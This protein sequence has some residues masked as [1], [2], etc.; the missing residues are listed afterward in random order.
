[1]PNRIYLVTNIWGVFFCSC[2]RCICIQLFTGKQYLYGK[3]SP[4]KK[5]NRSFSSSAGC[6]GGA[7]GIIYAK[8]IQY[9][10]TIDDDTLIFAPS[11]VEASNFWDALVK[12]LDRVGLLLSLGKTIITTNEAQPP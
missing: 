7:S 2:A 8:H 11:R 3:E 10:A 9:V 5:K 12:Q 1:M 6:F 4:P